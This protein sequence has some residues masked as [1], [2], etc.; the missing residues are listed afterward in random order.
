[1]VSRN[2]AIA[3]ATGTRPRSRVKHHGSFGKK[4]GKQ[5]GNS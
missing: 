1:M 2:D 5:P 4:Q 3:L